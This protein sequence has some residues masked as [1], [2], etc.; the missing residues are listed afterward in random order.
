MLLLGNCFLPSLLGQFADLLRYLISR[1]GGKLPIA[2]KF[3]LEMPLWFYILTA[4]SALANRGMFHSESVSFSIGAL[5]FVY[6]HSG[7]RPSFLLWLGISGV[8][9]PVAGYERANYGK[10]HHDKPHDAL[11]S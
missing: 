4:L 1:A 7:V 3:S 8:C 6:L 5:P 9:L 2:T 11:A 10:P